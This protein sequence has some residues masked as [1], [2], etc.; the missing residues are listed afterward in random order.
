MKWARLTIGCAALDVCTGGGIV[1]RGITEICGA[2][3][4]G[5]TQLLLQLSLC[6]QLPAR[7]GGLGKGVAYICTEDMFPSRR[8]LQISKAFEARYPDEQLNLLGNIFIE[9]QYESVSGSREFQ[10]GTANPSLPTATAAK[11]H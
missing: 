3:G 6:V 11:L 2:S 7:L 10:N 8:L 9:H 5:K 1:T 4:V